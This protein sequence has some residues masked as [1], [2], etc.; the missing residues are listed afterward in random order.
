MGAQYLAWAAHQ[1]LVNWRDIMGPHSFTVVQ[2]CGKSFSESG[3][4]KKHMRTSSGEISWEDSHRRE[5]IQVHQMWQYFSLSNNSKNH[6][7][8]CRDKTKGAQG[9][10]WASQDQM[11]CYFLRFIKGLHN[12]VE[13]PFKCTKCVP[14]WALTCEERGI[15]LVIL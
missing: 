7:T 5:G 3:G 6:K 1:D 13:K 11:T 10:A 9:L 2:K 4:L 14:E 15:Q 8:D 12:I